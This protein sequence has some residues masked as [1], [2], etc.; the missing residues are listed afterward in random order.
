MKI[1]I[2]CYPTFGGSGV[3]A[4]ELGK[5]LAEKGHE[6]HFITYSQPARLENF[7]K[8]LYFHEV[9]VLNYPLFQ[10]PPYELALT[11]KLV[12][13]IKYEQLD[14]L[15]VHYAIPHA[16]AAFMAK[17]ILETQNYTIPI[18]TTLHGT[19]ITLVGKD[20]TY[21]S[22]VT[23]S[24]NKSDGVTAVSQ[25]LK[26]ATYSNFD[27][28]NDI[29]VIPNFLDLKVINK[30]EY[31]DFKASIAANEEKIISHI[32][33]FREV[34]RVEDVVRI[35]SE[36]RKNTQAKLVMVGDGPER[37]TAEKICRE[38]PFCSDVQFLGKI[39]A[40]EKVLSISDLFLLPSETESFGLAALEA[41]ACEVP[42]IASNT[43]GL[44][45]VIIDQKNG[46]TCDVGDVQTMT[47]KGLYLLQNEELLSQF[48]K[49]A[50]ERAKSYDIHKILPIYE[51]YY[52]TILE[53]IKITSP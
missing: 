22:A 39:D 1:G 50:Y 29:E 32:S 48:K 53:R 20:A 26:D 4:T 38:S 37:A 35:F 17:Q 36:I 14:L 12:D 52:Q 10:Y 30:Q 31:P 5:A 40:V 42:V 44:P 41:M 15:H 2:V 18:V 51:D 3:V 47:E 23:F 13:I 45:E 34:K 46:F 27:I 33:N 43:G 11:S 9:N 6:V 8:N 19:D 49:A 21:E 24:I 25:Y 7:G 16:F 28:E